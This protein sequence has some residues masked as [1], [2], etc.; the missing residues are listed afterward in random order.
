M[1]N[2]RDTF[3]MTLVTHHYFVPS[4]LLGALLGAIT[5]A[6]LLFI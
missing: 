4:V 5:A 2:Q 6:A 1:V 3:I